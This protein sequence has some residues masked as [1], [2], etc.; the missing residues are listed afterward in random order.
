MRL[1]VENGDEVIRLDLQFAVFIFS[2]E[3]FKELLFNI[4]DS[5]IQ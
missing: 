5:S 2:S 4:K 3:C 1:R